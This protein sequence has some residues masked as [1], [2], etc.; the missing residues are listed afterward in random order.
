MSNF[1]EFNKINIGKFREELS[2][3][4]KKHGID[5][6]DLNVGNIRFSPTSCKIEVNAVIA[7]QPS[8]SQN[9]LLQVTTMHKLNMTNNQ[10]WKLVDY[11]SSNWKMPFIFERDGKRFKCSLSQAL[12][13]FGK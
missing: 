1:S 9:I 13:Y 2:E 4:L 11:K 3:L 7:G 12:I 10:G 6:V 8:A 5:G